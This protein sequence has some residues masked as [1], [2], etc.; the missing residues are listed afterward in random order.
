MK[1]AIR[2]LAL[3]TGA[4]AGLGAAFARAYAARGFDLALVAR[5]LDRLEAL[6]AELTKAHGVEAFAIQADLATI[7]VERLVLGAVA[8][9]G[10]KIDVLVN[11]AGFSIP[12]SFA[13]V[14]WERQRDFLMA[15][16]V[17]ACG[18]AHGVIPGMV[19]RG[20]GAIINNAS[21]AGFAPGT[22]GHTLYAGAK[23][24]AI[25]FSEALDAE[26]RAKGVR[27]TALCP[28][29]TH[30]DFGRANG[31]Q[32]AMDSSPRFFFQT[33]EAVVETAIH[34]NE[35]GRVVVVPGWHNKIAAALLRYLPDSLVKAVVRAGAEKYHLE[36]QAAAGI[37]QG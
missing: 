19:E 15:L 16:V 5:R 27:V 23:S 7:G 17:S 3:I 2:K 29:F 13:A 24:L 32:V 21:L 26:Y 37:E 22:P 20:R 14:P 6:G 10:G 25:K 36:G 9:R 18:L 12:Q 31:T 30:T 11:N 28:G 1:P 4:S 33:A 8:A 35:R 34:A